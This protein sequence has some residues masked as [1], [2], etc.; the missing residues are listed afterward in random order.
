MPILFGVPK[1]TKFYF[2]VTQMQK[3]KIIDPTGK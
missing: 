3:V 1:I 2:G